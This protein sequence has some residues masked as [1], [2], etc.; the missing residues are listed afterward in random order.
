MKFSLAATLLTVAT[1]TTVSAQEN[2]PS[3]TTDNSTVTELVD[4]NVTPTLTT[5]APQGEDGELQTI[6]EVAIASSDFNTLVAL[7]TQADLV[8]TLSG[9]GPF[10]VFAPKD[11]AF[12][13]LERV[14][15]KTAKLLPCLMLPMYQD[16][17]TAILTYHVADGMVMSADLTNGGKI[18]MLQGEEVSTTIIGKTILLNSAAV[19]DGIQVIGGDIVASNGV[20]HPINGILIPPSIDVNDFLVLCREENPDL[21]P[22]AGGAMDEAL[23]EDMASDGKDLGIATNEK[24]GTEGTA[25][26]T[27]GEEAKEEDDSAATVITT[28]GSI[29]TAAVVTVFGM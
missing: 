1:F 21:Q 20:I 14:N 2:G 4:P 7:L 12:E 24:D 3:L 27:E 16:Q 5:T 15:S 17:L 25:G 18:P 13:D 26:G 28:L 19:D 22:A 29:V 23:A 11:S 10:T 9:E 6:P 8:D